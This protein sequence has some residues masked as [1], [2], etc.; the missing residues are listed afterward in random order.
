MTP[1]ATLP[2]LY[3]LFFHKELV[4]L[5]K[6][7]PQTPIKSN[8]PLIIPETPITKMILSTLTPISKERMRKDLYQDTFLLEEQERKEL[9]QDPDYQEKMAN[10]RLGFYMESFVSFYGLCPVCR[11]NTLKKYFHSNVPVVDLVCINTEYHLKTNTCFLFQLKISLGN[12]Y[13]SNR[14]QIISIGSRKYGE[15][16]HTVIGTDSIDYKRV[17][18]GYI[19]LKLNQSGMQNYQIDL[20]NSFIIVPD[21]NNTSN[22]R[23][24]EY[25][26]YTDKY[27]KSMI[28]WYPTMFST[29]LIEE[30]L[31]LNISHEY[32]TETPIENPYSFF[33][34]S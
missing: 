7:L 33:F 2:T 18:P 31:P 12:E 8:R 25:L 16:P 23:Y 4:H 1:N 15:L 26:P 24:Y 9:E 19:C 11:E 6:N 3:K 34:K 5:S 13:F 10:N 27:G 32:F 29:P 28:T 22:Q 20:Q 14:D 30:I 17:V 21:F